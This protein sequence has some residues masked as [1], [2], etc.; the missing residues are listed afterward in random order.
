M[1]L[2]YFE[3]FKNYVP[4]DLSDKL[5]Q[6]KRRGES[7]TDDQIN[8]HV[9]HLVYEATRIF[10]DAYKA[11]Q[12]KFVFRHHSAKHDEVDERSE[13]DELN[14]QDDKENS[15]ISLDSSNWFNSKFHG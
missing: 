7:I 6:I 11:M 13:R 4:V 8:E 14:G 10:D 12:K 5:L 9:G 15:K 2:S 1:S 3:Y